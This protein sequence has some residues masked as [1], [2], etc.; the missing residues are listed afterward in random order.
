MTVDVTQKI[1]VRDLCA[2]RKCL[3][4]SELATEKAIR[5]ADGRRCHL[6]PP[7]PSGEGPCEFVV[8][9]LAIRDVADVPWLEPRPG[10]ERIGWKGIIW[11]LAGST[12]Q[13]R[14]VQ[15]LSAGLGVRPAAVAWLHRQWFMAL[16]DTGR[17]VYLKVD[18]DGVGRALASMPGLRTFCAG[19]EIQDRIQAGLQEGVRRVVDCWRQSHPG[20][21]ISLLPVDV[22]YI[23]GDD[24]FCVVPESLIESFLLG[25]ESAAAP[26]A[27]QS[28]TGALLAVQAGLGKPH[29]SKVP[30]VTSRLVPSLLKLVKARVRD[31]IDEESLRPLRE[32]AHE[33]GFHLAAADHGRLIGSRLFLWDFSLQ[34]D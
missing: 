32:S 28:F 20:E 17:F 24:V 1:S 13:M 5:E 26:K 11:S 16:H 2:R 18:G 15:G 27:I 21:E 3:T 34:V 14:Q 10:Q 25:F 30:E 7:P 22:V 9:D 6:V 4:E 31:R 23:G 19:L 8:G 12:N 29:G 33:Y